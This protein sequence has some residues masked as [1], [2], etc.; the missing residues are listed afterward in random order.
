MAWSHVLKDYQK[1][2]ISSFL[3]PEADML[4]SGYH[5]SQSLIAVGSG[6]G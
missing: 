5:A 2:R 4:G 6:Q 1:R 3:D